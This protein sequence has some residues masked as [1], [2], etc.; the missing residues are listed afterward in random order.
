MKRLATF[1]AAALAATSISLAPT[2][3]AA[4]AEDVAKIIAGLAVAGIIAKAID[5]RKDRK[6]AA[7]ATEY[8]RF[9]S[10][11]DNY[12][13]GRRTID[14][15]IRPYHQ[16]D[17]KR[18]PKSKRGYKKHALPKRCLLTVDT[19]RGS[20]L[21]YGARCLDRRYKF[22]SKLPRRCETVVRTPRGFRTVFG[23]R[24]LRRD[25]WQ[26]ARR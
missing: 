5:D 17:Y 1:A 21:A 19:G 23:A 4:D 3:A 2:P 18:G 7:T 12:Y 16:D 8:S 11:Y 13:D 9:G 6:R 10:R 24:C 26:V 15:T 14:G 25:G 22:A 20:R